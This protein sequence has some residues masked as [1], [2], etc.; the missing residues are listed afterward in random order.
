MILLTNAQRLEHLLAE[1]E[2]ITEGVNCERPIKVG[3]IDEAIADAQERV[4]PCMCWPCRIGRVLERAPRPVGSSAETERLIRKLVHA[5]QQ[6]REATRKLAGF[7]EKLR[8]RAR[9]LSER[10]RS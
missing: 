10:R 4:T 1:L 7:Q 6:E 9:I 5:E 3:S 2:R 8:R